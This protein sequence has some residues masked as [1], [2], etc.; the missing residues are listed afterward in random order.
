M[1]DDKGAGEWWLIM[2]MI[3]IIDNCE[4]DDNDNHGKC[5]VGDI[6]DVCNVDRDEDCERWR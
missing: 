2:V 4:D 1:M 6:D 5:D 3:M